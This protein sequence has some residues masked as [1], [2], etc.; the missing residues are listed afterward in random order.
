METKHDEVEDY[1]ELERICHEME[2]MHWAYDGL[3]ALSCDSHDPAVDGPESLL[4]VLNERLK[5]AVEALDRVTGHALI[6]ASERYPEICGETRE[7]RLPSHLPPTAGPGQCGAPF[8]EERN[9]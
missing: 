5:A 3:R 4:S 9:P 7:P 8:T 1:R 6:R 2:K